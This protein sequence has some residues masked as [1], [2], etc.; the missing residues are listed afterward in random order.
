MARIYGKGLNWTFSANDFTSSFKR[1]EIDKALT[2]LSKEG[3][4]RRVIQGVY[5]YPHY[6]EILQGLT[7]PDI[8]KIA[9]AL[10]R[11]FSWYIHPNGNTA[12]NYLGLSTQVVSRSIYLSDGPSRKYNIGNRTLEF[13]HTSMKESKLKYPISSL[14]VQALKSWGEDNI[15]YDFLR[16][17]ADKYSI[18]EWQKVK[19]DTAKTTGWIYKYITEIV[20]MLKVK[21]NG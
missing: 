9:H 21:K 7:P 10:A 20:D 3:K 19:K 15:D 11:K 8:D 2:A 13:K 1:W 16:K 12:L 18:I 14:I 5:D 6:S 17:L 4:I